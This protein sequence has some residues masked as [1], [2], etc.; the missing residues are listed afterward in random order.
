MPRTPRRK[1]KPN[2]DNL[3]ARAMDHTSHRP[4]N[5]RHRQ[6]AQWRMDP[7]NAQLVSRRVDLRSNGC[8]YRARPRSM[9]SFAAANRS[10]PTCENREVTG[11]SCVN[12]L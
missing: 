7:A 1:P 6:V 9:Q 8:P 12:R 10:W 5:I 3:T 2:I 4:N 11:E